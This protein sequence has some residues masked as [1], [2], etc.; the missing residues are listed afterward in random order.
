MAAQGNLLLADGQASPV[1]TTFYANGV[2]ANSDGSTIA[3]Y[4]SREASG[5]AIGGKTVT[6][7][8]RESA[9]KCD[10]DKRI[11]V[12]VLE[13]ISGSDGGYTPKPKVAY[14]ILSRE[15]F[16]LPARSSLAER[17]DQLAFSKNLNADAVMQNAVWNF[18]PVW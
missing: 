3:T 6:V 16:V 13:V 10:V 15:Q 14:N 2:K 8:V 18:E 1:T 5:I 12:P 4:R 17:K 9:Q 7:G 11:T